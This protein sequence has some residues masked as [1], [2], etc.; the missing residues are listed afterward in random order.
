MSR[1]SV[2]ARRDELVAVLLCPLG[3]VVEVRS[4]GRHGKGPS[5]LAKDHKEEANGDCNEVDVACLIGGENVVRDEDLEHGETVRKIVRCAV[6]EEEEAAGADD[7][8]VVCCSDPE[9]EIV[10]QAQGCDE[11]EGTPAGKVLPGCLSS[12]YHRCGESDA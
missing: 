3:R 1:V 4:G 2:D 8:N 11:G 6:G 5:G 10:E 12:E 9:L 7:G